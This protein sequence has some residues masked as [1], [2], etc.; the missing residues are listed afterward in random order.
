MELTD[1]QKELLCELIDGYVYPRFLCQC[2]PKV[3]TEGVWDLS[4]I[5]I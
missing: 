5:H 2:N 1:Q 4:L 3:D